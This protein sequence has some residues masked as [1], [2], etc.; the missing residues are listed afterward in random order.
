METYLNKVQV[1]ARDVITTERDD[2]KPDMATNYQKIVVVTRKTMLEELIER[3]GTRDQAAFLLKNR[4][5]SIDDFENAHVHYVKA[6]STLKAAIPSSVRHQIIERNYLPN[7]L[8]G[9][10]D[11][12]V[13]LGQ[14]GLVVNAAKYLQEQ[15]IVAFNPDPGRFDGVLIPF[16][17]KGA[18]ATID[19]ALNEAL[20]L[21]QITMARAQLDDG[22]VLDAV[23]DLFVGIQGHA[24]ARYRLGFRKKQE[25]QSSSGIIISTGAGST[26]WFR[27]IVTGAYGVAGGFVEREQ[28]GDLRENYRFDMEADELRFSVREPF[29]SNTSKADLIYGRIQSRDTLEIVSR[30]PQRGIIFSDGME[31]DFL[32]F[33]SGMRAKITVAQRKVNL[34]W[35]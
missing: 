2:D 19:A 21:K 30:M 14:D 8:F 33:E 29:I 16:T 4:G 12:V 31:S 3:H 26:G 13:T 17:M 32:K 20:S 7:F 27:S 6:L 15:P 25:E 5:Q 22:Q 11:L 28:L 24:S 23:N 34:F 9:P 1:V 35:K 10:H 18:K